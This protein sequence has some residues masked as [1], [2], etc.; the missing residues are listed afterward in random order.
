MASYD[1]PGIRGKRGG[2]VPAERDAAA[3]ARVVLLEAEV[4]RLMRALGPYR[5]LSRDALARAS[6][7]RRW[8]PGHLD[9]A[10]S[11]AVSAG[12]LRRLPLGYYGFPPASE[13]PADETIAPDP[14]ASSRLRLAARA[15]RPAL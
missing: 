12:R 5:V 8:Q 1:P 9:R 10:L 11:A 3:V 14:N 2:P 6:G 15:R 4:R 13:R 7:A